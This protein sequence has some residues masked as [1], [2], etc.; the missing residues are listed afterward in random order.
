MG[1]IVGGLLVAASYVCLGFFK[2]EDGMICLLPEV[3]LVLSYRWLPRS[4]LE[5]GFFLEFL[6]L[7]SNMTLFAIFGGLVGWGFGKICRKQP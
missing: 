3:S 4:I 7:A 5:S 1:A 6:V 2:Y